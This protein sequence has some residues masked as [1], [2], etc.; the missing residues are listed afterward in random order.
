EHLQ[1]VAMSEGGRLFM[2]RD[3]K[4]TFHDAGRFLR[5]SREK[6][7]QAVYDDQAVVWAAISDVSWRFDDEFLWDRVVAVRNNGIPQEA[8]TSQYP[9]R[10]KELSGLLMRTDREALQ[11]AQRLAFRYQ[12]AQYRCDGWEAK[13]QVR[14]ATWQVVLGLE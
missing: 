11:L 9:R 2:S 5:E 7:P 8:S 10:T 6:A 4:V 1:Q 13:P 3:G 12:A 14:P